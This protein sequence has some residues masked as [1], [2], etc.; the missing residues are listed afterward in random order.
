MVKPYDAIKIAQGPSKLAA[1]SN[2]AAP[3]P[4]LDNVRPATA[5]PSVN[6]SM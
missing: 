4:W 5:T 1:P 3:L 2:P 6:V